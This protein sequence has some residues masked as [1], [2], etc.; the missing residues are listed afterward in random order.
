VGGKRFG[1]AAME[2]SGA[3]RSRSR[4]KSWSRR[5]GTLTDGG[6]EAKRDLSLGKYRS[7]NARHRSSRSMSRRTEA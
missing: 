3:V 1:G 2:G 6:G 4:I 5:K 7:I